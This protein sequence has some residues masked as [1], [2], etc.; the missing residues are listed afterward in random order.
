MRKHSMS[1]FRLLRHAAMML[2]AAAACYFY[3]I[4]P[5]QASNSDQTPLKVPV[6]VAQILKEGEDY[7][8]ASRLYQLIE[9]GIQ[10]LIGIDGKSYIDISKVQEAGSSPDRELVNRV[11]RL[12]VFNHPEY[13][14]INERSGPKWKE[15][16]SKPTRL[17]GLYPAYHV[18]ASDPDNIG[19]LIDSYN[20]AVD[21]LI[22][23]T[24]GITDPVEQML[25]IYDI[26]AIQNMYNWE[27]S[28]GRVDEA[29]KECWNSMSA[30]LGMESGPVCRG[31][32]LAYRTLLTRLGIPCVLVGSDEMDHVWNM[33]EIDGEYYHIDVDRANGPVPS[34]KGRSR[35]ES[36]LRSDA[37]MQ[38]LEYKNWTIEGPGLGPQ[39]APVCDSA[40]YESADWAFN[41]RTDFPIYRWNDSY[42]Y[43]RRINAR[44][45]KLYHGPV[46]GGGVH[47]ADLPI[48]TRIEEDAYYTYSGIVWLNGNLYYVDMDQN[49]IRY[50]LSSGEKQTCGLI[51]FTPQ[52]SQDGKFNEFRD[53]IGL[54]FDPERQEIVA[55]SRA[56]REVLARF[57]A[58]ADA[59]AFADVD[60]NQWFYDSVQQA[61]VDG[62][63]NGAAYDA[64]TGTRIFRPAGA[65]TLA[66]FTAIVTR[67]FYPTEVGQ[68][69]ASQPWY[70]PHVKV[71][72]SH[73]LLSDIGSRNFNSP[74]T[75]CQMAQMMLNILIDQGGSALDSAAVRE[76][77][78]Q[79]PDWDT[80]DAINRTA[81]ATCYSLGLLKGTDSSGTF[82][83][84]A[85]MQRCEC[86]AVYI[87][88]R[89]HLKTLSHHYSD[90]Y[91]SGRYYTALKNV[92]LT[93]DYRKDIIAVAASQI[94]YC[95]SDSDDELRG[96]KAGK[97]NYTEYGRFMGTNGSAWCSEFA[98]WC[99]RQAG[100]P[101]SIV[102]SSPSANVGIFAA[103]YYGW[104]DTVYA[105]G[106]YT[107]QAGD[108]ILFAWSGTPHTQANLSHTSI[109]ESVQWN[110]QNLVFHTIEGNIDN[111]VTRRSRTA[112]PSNGAVSGGDI[113]YF[114]APEY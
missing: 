17:I 100:V 98:S 46:S 57:P 104:S 2:I 61:F 13:F 48:Y 36:F 89:D 43:V 27:V 86:A 65:V 52:S 70:T 84:A 60:S 21:S 92:T 31:T 7:N 113:V 53:G 99:I 18:Y 37:A 75:R 114:I 87:R 77:A 73:N 26:L 50:E 58:A 108:L 10:N 64:A 4:T 12:V 109:V 96:V 54:S 29:P 97:S 44:T 59:G 63:V 20:K 23:Q 8:T 95:E 3:F 66:E 9:D 34:L 101:A 32:A 90:S 24:A 72:D 38:K 42:Y 71:A 93:G 55:S 40:N 30:I 80:V 94:G 79:I 19:A 45:C 49:L 25:A 105:G 69:D 47:L 62:A 68:R 1:A 6:G 106:R 39:K 67:A 5:V 107:P 28:V 11:Y 41:N 91:Q 14:Y 102:Q 110:G 103:P 88:L 81:V 82:N 111:K 35:H 76:I 85:T 33:V 74:V 51:P 56:R 22:A 83:G 112:N 16:D 15:S 78:P